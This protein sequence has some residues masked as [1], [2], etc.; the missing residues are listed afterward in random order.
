M[1]GL[2]GFL[3]GDTAGCDRGRWHPGTAT[4]QAELGR[5]VAQSLKT[6]LDG[7]TDKDVFIEAKVADRLEAEGISEDALEFFT[8]EAEAQRIK[9]YKDGLILKFT[10]EW[11]N[12]VFDHYIK[13]FDDQ[14]GAQESVM[15]GVSLLSPYVAMRTLSAALSG[16]DFAHHRH[17]TAYAEAWRQGFVDSLNQAFAD[18]AGAQGWSYRAGPELW[19][20]APPFE[21]QP[22]KP[23]LDVHFLSALALLGWLLMAFVLARW[24][25][26]RVR[27]V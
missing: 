27:V 24:A 6:G 18:K 25:A 5:Q 7:E 17:F 22:P 26:G 9:T 1:V 16:T 19:K 23:Q 11:E 8:D 15:D 20:N 13:K 21:Y 2:W 10:A 3:L 14:V 12:A 4:R